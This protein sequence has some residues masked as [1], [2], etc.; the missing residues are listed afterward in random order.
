METLRTTK[1]GL[2]I[3]TYANPSLHSFCLCLYVKAGPLYETDGENGITHFW[4]HTVFRSIDAQMKRTLF[5]TLDSHA[6]EFSGCTYKE[7]VQLKITGAAKNF[8]LAAD[9]FTKLFSPMQATGADIKIERSRIKA[10]MREDDEKNSL[11][12]FSNR[13][14]WKGTSLENTVTGANKVLDKIG[15]AAL[16][17]AHRKL[18]SVNNLFLYVTGCV[19]ER[20][21]D[22][23]AECMERL[24]LEA[25]QPVRDNAASVPADFFRRGAQIMVKNDT[26]CCVQ[27]SFDVPTASYSEAELYLLYDILFS[28]DSCRIFQELSDRTGYIYS[29]DAAFEQYVNIGNLHFQYE[30]QAKNL[31]ASIERVV[32]V[33]A[34]LKEHP[35]ELAYV[36]APYTENA[37]ILLDSD[38]DLNWNMAYDSHILRQG[39][40]SVGERAKAYEA[41]TPGRIREIAREIF[42]PDNMVVTMKT[43]K[44]KLDAGKIRE[45]LLRI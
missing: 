41:V 11:D 44:K 2:P 30:V 12:Y 32:A 36:K 18:L 40:S 27:F 15:V 24:P 19:E 45:L 20:D 23:L 16:Q 4:E 39:F 28:G 8:S 29:Y 17:A 22:F 21:I 26:Y 6:L 14:I 38:E 33:L 43:D 9:I 7:F 5:Q 13:I 10:E 25:T 42:V 35:A 37:D 34:D 31:P 1:N 3:Y